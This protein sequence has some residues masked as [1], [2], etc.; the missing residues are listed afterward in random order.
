M[1]DIGQKGKYLGNN[2]LGY[3]FKGTHILPFNEDAN[4][5]DLWI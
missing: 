2:L 4:E 5:T 3:S 1:G